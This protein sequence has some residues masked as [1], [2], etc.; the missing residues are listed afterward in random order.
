[1]ASAVLV[2]R[3][4][5]TSWRP[6]WVPAV[7]AALVAL[8]ALAFLVKPLADSLTVLGLSVFVILAVLALPPS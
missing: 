7:L 6:S 5:W 1:M 4:S 3:P 2:W 8:V